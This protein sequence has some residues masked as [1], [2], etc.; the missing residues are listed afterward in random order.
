MEWNIIGVVTKPQALK[1]EFRL[2]PSLLNMKK[3][4]KISFVK[5]DNEEYSVERVSLRDAFVILKLQGIDTCESAER[6]RNKEVF[7]CIEVDTA[8]HFDLDGFEVLLNG[9]NVGKVV[10]IDNFGSKD[11]LSVK[12]ERSFMLPII[13][14]IILDVNNCQKTV[15]LDS[16][17]FEEVAVYED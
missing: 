11:I 8:E 6:L 5:I 15:V 16:K 2:K 10:S 14:G 1:G 12:G 9:K 3:Y 4:K 17:I 13:D 7:A